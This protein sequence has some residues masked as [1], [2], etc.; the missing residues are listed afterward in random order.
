LREFLTAQGLRQFTDTELAEIEAE[1]LIYEPE[2]ENVTDPYFMSMLN[3]DR[4][5]QVG[6]KIYRYVNE[7]VIVYDASY[8]GRF[9]ELSLVEPDAIGM[10]HGQQIS[11]SDNA[12]FIKIDYVLSDSEESPA[13][14]NAFDDYTGHNPYRPDGSLTMPNNVT[15]PK[16][17]VRTVSFTEG[18]GD[19][20]P[21]QKWLSGISGV[22]VTVENEFNS[23]HRMKARMYTQDY[24]IFKSVG[25]TVRMQHKRLGIWWRR[26]AQEFRYGWTAIE[27]VHEFKN[28][29]FQEPPKMPNGVPTRNRFP[30]LIPTMSSSYPYP[31]KNGNIVLFHV[32]NYNFT[33]GDIND[34]YAKASNALKSYITNWRTRPES[35]SYKDTPIGFYG[36]KEKDRTVRVIV[37]D[38]Y[39]Q[40]TGQGREVVKWNM[41]GLEGRIRMSYNFPFKIQTSWRFIFQLILF[42]NFV[43]GC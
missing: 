42:C 40:S 28:F 7:G 29:P 22:N 14:R 3:K 12:E 2:D 39:D 21:F 36:T 38:A 8:A 17:R 32:A 5:I 37:P 31:F 24:I 18:A 33:S 23:T 15:I 27:L 30:E 41:N 35:Q 16:D 11:L 10:V 25:M 1:G 43:S 4:E 26:D 6:A 34:V 19:G 20:T 9:E 13:T